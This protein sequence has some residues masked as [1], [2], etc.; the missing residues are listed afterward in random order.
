MENQVKNGVEIEVANGVGKWSGEM[1]W[2]YGV[3][4]GVENA[5]KKEWKIG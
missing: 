4:N 2:G 3:E 5:L 1:E